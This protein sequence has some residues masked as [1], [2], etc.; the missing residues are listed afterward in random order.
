M[1]KFWAVIAVL[2]LSAGMLGFMATGGSAG[3]TQQVPLNNATAEVGTDCPDTVNS[4]WHFV[5]T[6][7]NEDL[8]IESITLNLGGGFFY[9]VSGA[10]LIFNGTQTDNVFVKVPAGYTLT[11]LQ[12]AGSF[13]EVSGG[14]ANNFLLS[15]VCVGVPPTTTTT[16]A[17]AAPVPAAAAAKFT[18]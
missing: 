6:P 7:N 4:Y 5:V 10:N 8:V 12:L 16:T 3:V 14:E 11:S 2:G 15:H 1:R 18:G 17:P 9:V 13:A